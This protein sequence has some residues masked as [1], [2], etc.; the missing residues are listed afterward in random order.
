MMPPSTVVAWS[1]SPS[2]TVVEKWKFI[3]ILSSWLVEKDMN[4]SS[5]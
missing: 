1:I 2:E 4:D 3:T 5:S